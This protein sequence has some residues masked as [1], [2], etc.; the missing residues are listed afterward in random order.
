MTEFDLTARYFTR[1]PKQAVVGVGDDC[2]LINPAPRMQM[3]ISSD[4]LAEGRYFLNDV[5]PY[6]FISIQI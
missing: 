1:K 2:A 5:S 4:M 3:A 6:L